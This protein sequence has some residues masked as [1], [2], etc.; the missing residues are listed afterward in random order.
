M[1]KQ[2]QELYPWSAEYVI[3]HAKWHKSRGRR[4]SV[5]YRGIRN[6]EKALALAIIMNADQQFEDVIIESVEGKTFTRQDGWSFAVQAECTVIPKPGDVARFY[7]R[8]IGSTVRGLDINGVQC[9]YRTEKQQKEEDAQWVENYH[10]EKKAEF[11]KNKADMDARY[12]KLP[13]LFQKRIDK[14]RTNNPDF[15]WEYEPYEMF[16]C[17]QAVVI[18]TAI[19]KKILDDIGPI[20]LSLEEAKLV[21]CQ[22]APETIEKFTKMDWEDQKKSIPELSDGHSGNTFGCAITLTRLYLSEDSGNI[23]KMHGALSPLVG[24]KEY[25]CIPRD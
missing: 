20:G 3:A 25:G 19:G 5:Q 4:P 2:F 9:Y 15:R 10:A 21:V 14:F 6:P 8:G 17:E 7:G 11:E 23:V 22:K 24:S 12:Q 18:A 13:A 1:K 16:C